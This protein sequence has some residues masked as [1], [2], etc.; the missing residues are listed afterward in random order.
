[1]NWM[2]DVFE[3]AGGLQQRIRIALRRSALRLAY[4]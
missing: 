2:N 4:R 3:F 1:M